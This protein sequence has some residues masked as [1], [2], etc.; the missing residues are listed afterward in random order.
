[1]PHSK[2]HI[3]VI[4]KLGTRKYTYSP[5]HN[6]RSIQMV[7][8]NIQRKLPFHSLPKKQARKK[9]RLIDSWKWATIYSHYHIM[10][11][12]SCICQWAFVLAQQPYFSLCNSTR[13]FQT[14]INQCPTNSDS[15][16]ILGLVVALVV[17]VKSISSGEGKERNKK[18]VRVW[19]RRRNRE[20]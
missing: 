16:D 8:F 12:V 19:V 9:G 13:S 14:T 4:W 20:K 17:I 10:S 18:N 3:S 15:I 6:W 5:Q 7:R 2:A 11:V 1:M